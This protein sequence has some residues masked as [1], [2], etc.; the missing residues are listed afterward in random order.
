MAIVH[1]RHPGR[2]YSGQ[3][4]IHSSGRTEVSTFARNAVREEIRKTTS[5]FFPKKRR[6]GCVLAIS[7]V[8]SGHLAF[9]WPTVQVSIPSHKEAIIIYGNKLSPGTYRL[10]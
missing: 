10:L 5:A 2:S 6:G 7:L 3:T 9:L 1:Y 8:P 4:L